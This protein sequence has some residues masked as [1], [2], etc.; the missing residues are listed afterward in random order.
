MMVLLHFSSTARQQRCGHLAHKRP[1]LPVPAPR[2]PHNAL[3][4]VAPLERQPVHQ[5]H[6][7]HHARPTWAQRPPR[8][9]EAAAPRA[10]PRPRRLSARRQCC[11][12]ATIARRRPTARARQTEA[13][14]GRRRLSA[15]ARADAACGGG[16]SAAS[17]SASGTCGTTLPWRWREGR[18]APA[19]RSRRARAAAR[20]APAA[21]RAVL[22]ARPRS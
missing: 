12:S 21:R 18:A 10:T 16:P 8:R 17:P 7:Q 4:V 9:G 3:V 14:A 19:R 15:A 11:Q 13:A 5:V 20:A 22:G 2:Q 1:R 6:G